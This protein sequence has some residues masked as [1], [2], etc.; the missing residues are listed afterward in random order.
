MFLAIL[1]LKEFGGAITVALQGFVLG[2]GL[3]MAMLADLRV[4]DHA[5]SVSLGNLS[6]GMVPCILLSLMLPLGLGL[7]EA[8]DI[9]LTDDIV[10]AA[11][12]HEKNPGDLVVDSIAEAKAEAFIL[13]EKVRLSSSLFSLASADYAS[14]FARETAA[15]QLSLRCEIQA[16]SAALPV[17]P[18]QSHLEEEPKRPVTSEKNMVGEFSKSCQQPSVSIPKKMKLEQALCPIFM[19]VWI[20]SLGLDRIQFRTSAS[21]V[22]KAKMFEIRRNIPWQAME[23]LLSRLAHSC[24]TK[25][26]IQFLFNHSLCAEKQFK[27]PMTSRQNLATS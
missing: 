16:I 7:A 15:L 23:G 13:Q 24:F 19:P 4:L 2:G 3:A 21:K 12:W 11:S 10:S 20:K 14:R 6:R 22:A 9:Y 8:L 1:R 25:T 26:G 18:K 27:R 17:G 5:A